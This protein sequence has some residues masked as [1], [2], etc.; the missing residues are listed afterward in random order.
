MSKDLL[1]MFDELDRNSEDED[2]ILRAP[3][4]WPGGKTR[5]VKFIL[6]HLPYRKTYCEPYGGSGAVLL[7]RHKSQ[8]EIY[9]D[10]YGGVVAFYQCLRDARL[11]EELVKWLDLT[12]NAREEWVNCSTTWSN[13]NDPVERAGRWYYMHEYSFGSLGR[14][15]GRARSG[16]YKGIN[17]KIRNKIKLFPEIHGRFQNVQVENLDGIE[18]MR[19]YDSPE[20]VFYLDPPYMDADQ[21]MYVENVNTNYHRRLLDTIFKTRGFVAISGYANDIYD[22]RNWDNILEWEVF[23]SI[24]GLRG[25]KKNNLEGLPLKRGHVMER[26][27]IKEAK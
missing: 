13:V 21:Q 26:L 8:L 9:N 17:G 18:C 19:Q 27:W 4:G 2:T 25:S 12:V 22:A 1:A 6:P 20:T 11:Y 23:V 15:W 24:Q 3:F 16:A 10:R 14:N 7:G 5:S